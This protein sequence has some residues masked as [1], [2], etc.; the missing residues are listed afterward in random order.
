MRPGGRVRRAG[1]VSDQRTLWTLRDGAISPVG[2]R[3]GITDGI[4]T[5][6]DARNLHEGDQIVTDVEGV[7]DD[8]KQPPGG[9]AMRRMF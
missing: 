6:I 2:V 3:I 4:F 1:P 8:K 7:G 5:E 9:N